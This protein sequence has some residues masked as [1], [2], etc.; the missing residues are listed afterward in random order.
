MWQVKSDIPSILGAWEASLYSGMITIVGLC[1]RAEVGSRI[2]DRGSGRGAAAHN[3]GVR[4][5]LV[6]SNRDV[7]AL[8]RRRFHA[9]RDHQPD[10]NT[11]NEAKYIHRGREHTQGP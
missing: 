1:V 7:G 8:V 5:S 3:S 2:K 4:A 9:S 10:M 6:P 11:F